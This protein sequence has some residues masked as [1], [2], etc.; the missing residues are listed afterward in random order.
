MNSP[1]GHGIGEGVLSEIRGVDI[2]L[3]DVDARVHRLSRCDPQWHTERALR[4]ARGFIQR[5]MVST[6]HT[7]TVPRL[8]M[9]F[10]EAIAGAARINTLLHE[11]RRVARPRR[12]LRATSPIRT[13]TTLSRPID[14]ETAARVSVNALATGF[15]KGDF[16]P[17]KRDAAAMHARVGYWCRLSAS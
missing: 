14:A 12:T 17:G 5:E 15:G 6:L 4:R 16:G 8:E 13:P 9:V 3:G 11:M 7:R 10:D 2:P 1:L